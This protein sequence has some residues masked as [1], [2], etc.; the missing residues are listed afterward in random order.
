LV[1]GLSASSAGNIAA[2]LTSST[3]RTLNMAI[4][5]NPAAISRIMV[6]SRGRITGSGGGAVYAGSD[7]VDTNSNTTIRMWNDSGTTITKF[8]MVFEN[9]RTSNNGD[10]AT[11][12]SIT[13]SAGIS[14][15]VASPRQQVI[16]AQVIAANENHLTIEF[17][18]STPWAP[19]DPM[20]VTSYAVV[21]AGGVWPQNYELNTAMGEAADFNTG[22]DKSVSGTITN[23]TPTANR[24]GYGPTAIVATAWTG[25]IKSRAI[26]GLGDSRMSGNTASPSAN[27][28]SG[29]YGR[30]L[31][32]VFPFLN[33]GIFSA[34]IS[35]N[36]SQM[37]R[38]IDLFKKCGITDIIVMYGTNDLTSGGNAA[39]IWGNLQSLITMLESEGFRVWIST[40]DP[41]V[42]SVDDYLTTEGMSANGASYVGGANS[43]R[44]KLNVLI[45][46]NAPGGRL[47]DTAATSETSPGSGVLHTATTLG[48]NGF[49]DAPLSFAVEGA[50]TTTSIDTNSTT[51]SPTN[52]YSTGNGRLYMDTG[53]ASPASITI[54]TGPNASGVVVLDSTLGTAPAV[55]DTGR[56]IAWPGPTTD[57]VHFVSGTEGA[58]GPGQKFVAEVA[59]RPLFTALLAA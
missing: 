3:G 17:T 13:V 5:V 54:S 57:G 30:G 56:L 29:T 26:A 51:P 23:A 40:I 49:F 48:G 59:V 42:S 39:T 28:N 7:G 53:A 43:E 31:N 35:A 12:N 55:G 22:V 10:V 16:S 34:A 41:R 14:Y 25:S 36:L 46:A 45:R 32:G 20:D 18:P 9:A 50:S 27:G 33:A 1:V 44:H 4:T 19:G 2:V 47:V 21:A 8:R 6:S 58:N 15:P 52:K 38:R 11:S 37:S 24:R